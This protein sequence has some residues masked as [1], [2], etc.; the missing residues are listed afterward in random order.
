MPNNDVVLKNIK[1]LALK[2]QNLLRILY[3]GAVV[4]PK[5]LV[6]LDRK[7]TLF[8]EEM[9]EA[10]RSYEIACPHCKGS[11]EV[12]VLKIFRGSEM[13][14][15]IAVSCPECHIFWRLD[16]EHDKDVKKI[17]AHAYVSP[18]NLFA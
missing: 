13:T 6:N 14:K 16:N 4:P 7:V 8:H 18:L 5:T 10:I 2:I 11:Y 17:L 1:S 3:S 12:R 15:D 9:N